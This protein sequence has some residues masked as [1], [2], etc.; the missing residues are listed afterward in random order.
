MST[1]SVRTALGLLAGPP[2]AS[3]GPKMF[4]GPGGMKGTVSSPSS[5]CRLYPPALRSSEEAHAGGE[6]AG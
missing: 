5:P 6:A 3:E 2:R 1:S 4:R